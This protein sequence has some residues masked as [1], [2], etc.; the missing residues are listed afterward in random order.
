[1][2]WNQAKL[3]DLGICKDLDGL[4]ASVKPRKQAPRK[5]PVALEPFERRTS[6][7]TAGKEVQYTFPKYS[8]QEHRRDEDPQLPPEFQGLEKEVSSALTK[9]HCWGPFR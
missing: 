2:Q 1:M 6:S 3:R 7:R 4:R 8:R 5:A 9:R